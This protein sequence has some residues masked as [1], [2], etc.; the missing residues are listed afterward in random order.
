MEI[1][2]IVVDES[3][4][5][6]KWERF[7]D[8]AK[9]QGI[10]T[11]E[12]LFIRQQHPGMPDGQILHYLLDKTTVFLTTDQPFHNKVLSEGLRSYYIDDDKITNSRLR[13]IRV[14]ADRFIVKKNVIRKKNYHQEKCE[15]RPLLLPDS[16]SQLKKLNTK[17]RR[18][19]NHFG[20]FDNLDQIAVTVSWEK[21]NNKNL[22]GI[23]IRVSSNVGIK[24]IDASESYIAESITSEHQNIVSICHALAVVIR[25]MLHSVKTIVYYDANKIELPVQH[26]KNSQGDHY[27]RFFNALNESF[28]NLEFVSTSKGKYIEKL[29]KKLG[30]L[31][32]N[33][34]TNEIISGDIEKMLNSLKDQIEMGCETMD[35][36][37]N[38]SY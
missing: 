10:C 11:S 35:T 33:K 17:R 23:L 7:E 22:I 19:R 5:F 16:S 12:H 6:S 8:F 4:S 31:V 14:N 37:Q 38:A 9:E 26:N 25:L 18:I 20:G 29:R 1:K 15:I 24:A 3:V 36:E 34:K 27:L 30:V 2:R 13:G 21:A 32:G 28:E